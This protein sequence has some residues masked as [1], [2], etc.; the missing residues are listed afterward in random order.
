MQLLPG[1]NSGLAAT[2]AAAGA[3]TRAGVLQSI[4]YP[5]VLPR[6]E[7]D[8]TVRG[9][10]QCAWCMQLAARVSGRDRAYLVVASAQRLA[11]KPLQPCYHAASCASDSCSAH[12]HACCTRRAVG[13]PAAEGRHAMDEGK[14]ARCACRFLRCIDADCSMLAPL[15]VDGLGVHFL[16]ARPASELA[17]SFGCLFHGFGASCLS[18]SSVCQQLSHMLQAHVCAPDIPAFGFS[19]RPALLDYSRYGLPYHRRTY[20][21]DGDRHNLSARAQA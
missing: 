16:E 4:R 10:P 11:W 14:R 20:A 5:S 21:S 8:E 18:W 15:Q 17:S 13:L 9:M 2:A 6:F 3:A 19:K 7:H 1:P 12:Y